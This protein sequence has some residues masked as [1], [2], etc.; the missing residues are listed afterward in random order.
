MENADLGYKTCFFLSERGKTPWGYDSNGVDGGSDTDD[1]SGRDTDENGG[2]NTDDDGGD[3]SGPPS[4]SISGPGLQERTPLEVQGLRA[5]IG[6]GPL[7]PTYDQSLETTHTR[8]SIRIHP[9]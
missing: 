1:D 4:G 3:D 9:M 2:S 7:R 6:C 5:A 8:V